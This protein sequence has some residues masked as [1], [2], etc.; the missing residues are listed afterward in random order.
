MEAGQSG[1]ETGRS[2][3]EA[4]QLGCDAGS[5]GRLVSSSGARCDLSP[6]TVPAIFTSERDMNP[7]LIT[8]ENSTYQILQALKTNRRKRR[9]LHEVFVEGVSAIKQGV[10]SGLRVKRIISQDDRTL[11]R[12]ARGLIDLN[13]QAQYLRLSKRLFDELSDRNDPSEVIITLDLP[14]SKIEEESES[15][16]P[17]IVVIDRPTNHG[18]LGTI[19]RSANAFGVTQVLTVGHGVDVYDP[20]VIRASMGSVFSTPVS[21]IESMESLRAW[22]DQMR[23]RHPDL[24]V[25]ATDSSGDSLLT[26]DERTSLPAAIL[27]GNEAK[28][29]S[30][31]LREVADVTL[32]IPMIGTVDSLNVACAASIV[33]YIVGSSSGPHLRKAAG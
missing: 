25:I 11:S 1:C 15:P 20:A 6:L 21:Q 29:L 31:H 23:E 30:V 5:A 24:R 7:L 9:E 4:G 26:G 17:F 13:R 8:K 22:L 10:Q 18:N 32:R 3:R 33:M 28:G 16:K 19:V 27:I 14:D 12:W 2:G